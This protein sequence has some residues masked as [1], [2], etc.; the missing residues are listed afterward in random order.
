MKDKLNFLPAPAKEKAMKWLHGFK[1]SS[2]D[3]RHL[4]TDKAG[5]IFYSETFIIPEDVSESSPVDG[6]PDSDLT[7]EN[8][9]TLNSKPGSANTVYLD[10]N[11]HTLSGTAWNGSGGTLNARSYDLDGAPG[12]YNASELANIAEIWRRVSEDYAPFDINVTTQ[13][14][15]AFGPHTGRLL[16]TSDTDAN[17]KAMPY[18]GAGGVAY[19]N[20]WGRS[21]YSSYYS[22]ALVYYNRLGGGR[23]DYVSEAASHEFG[24]NLSLSHD[25][26]SSSSY[27]GGHGSGPTSWGPIMGTGYNR[28]VSQWSKGEYPDANNKQDDIA[29][30][31]GKLNLL[32]D[33]HADNLIAQTRLLSDPLGNI[34]ATTPKDDFYNEVADNKGIIGSSSDVD[35]F[36][37]DASAG[38]I[39]LTVTPA[40]QERYTDGGNLDLLVSLYDSAGILV[41]IQRQD[42][43]P[44]QIMNIR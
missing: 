36:Y 35:V 3:V 13:E 30:I 34:S 33:D 32:A 39:N 43:H 29:I 14:P 2:Q 28:N 4:R 21:N 11:G 27:Y 31:A 18:R 23:A 15:S 42:S 25:A 24:H 37:F 10:F 7:F 40:H 9:F 5:G 22:P 16:I 20:V 12:T 17:G 1:F 19:V 6:Q 26:T 44:V 41:L 38:E 8:V